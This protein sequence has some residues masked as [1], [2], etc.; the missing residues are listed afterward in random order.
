M[1]V[2]VIH[3]AVTA[4]R[5]MRAL[6]ARSAMGRTLWVMKKASHA[7]LRPNLEYD[8]GTPSIEGPREWGRRS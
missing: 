7:Q 6:W 3:K 8:L 4:R 2:A 1:D 5:T